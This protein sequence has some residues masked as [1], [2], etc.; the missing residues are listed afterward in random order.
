MGSR[1]E[2]VTHYNMGGGTVVSPDVRASITHCSSPNTTST[3][4]ITSTITVSY[5]T[6]D[7]IPCSGGE[8][9]GGEWY[10]LLVYTRPCTQQQL[11]TVTKVDLYQ[12]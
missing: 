9:G 11:Y 8:G 1:E 6:R 5:S 4:T 10:Q 7:I 2:E 3:A 12:S